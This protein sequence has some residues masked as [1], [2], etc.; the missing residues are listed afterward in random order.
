[1]LGERPRLVG[2]LRQGNGSPCGCLCWKTRTL[3]PRGAL[4]CSVL[5]P[6]PT[7]AP[8]PEPWGSLAPKLKE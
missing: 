6:A 3:A 7:P 2:R 1:M 8:E 4:Q 5:P